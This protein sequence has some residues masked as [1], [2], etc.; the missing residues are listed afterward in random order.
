V[1]AASSSFFDDADSTEDVLTTRDEGCSLAPTFPSR[2]KAAVLSWIPLTVRSMMLS[3]PLL[4]FPSGV[5]EI[6]F[7]RRASTSSWLILG[8]K[9][10]GLSLRPLVFRNGEPEFDWIAP[11][12][13]TKLARTRESGRVPE[14]PGV[15]EGTGVLPRDGGE[16]IG[17]SPVS[18]LASRL[19]TPGWALLSDIVDQAKRSGEGPV[20]AIAGGGKGQNA[21]SA[22]TARQ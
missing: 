18:N 16:V 2:L 9:I 8:P 10:P 7:C 13:V 20:G 12:T 17:L 14:D 6:T 5:G 1:G 4:L 21:L 22:P 19:R 15:S 3:W 11:S